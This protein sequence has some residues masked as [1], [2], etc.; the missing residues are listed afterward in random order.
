MAKGSRLLVILNG[1]KAPFA[2]VNYGTGKD[3]SDESITDA[4]APLQIQWHNDSFVTLP[5][6]K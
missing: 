1:L 6:R 5:L 4:D 3:V 2:P